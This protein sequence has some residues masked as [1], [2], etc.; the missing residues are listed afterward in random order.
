M[1]EKLTLL[2]HLDVEL[3]PLEALIG[4]LIFGLKFGSGS[5]LEPRKELMANFFIFIF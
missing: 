4:N 5:V 1:K 2:L 3:E